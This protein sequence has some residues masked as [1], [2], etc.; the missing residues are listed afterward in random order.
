MQTF[1]LIP[2]PG[3]ILL[4]PGP[5]MADPRVLAALSQPLIGHLDPEFLKLMAQVQE[6]L[7]FVFET[8]NELTLAVPGTGSAAMETAVASLVEES[9]PVLVC[10][11]G[12]FG[13]RIA[14]MARIYR[15]DLT[16]MQKPMGNI[17]YPEEIRAELQGK[18]Y[19]P[20]AFA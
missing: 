12:Y 13:N 18:K 19:F 4:G 3:R 5:S 11:Q 8:H 9:T 2:N 10:V 17:F 20:S 15:A 1:D 6:L 14:E 7:R 16:V